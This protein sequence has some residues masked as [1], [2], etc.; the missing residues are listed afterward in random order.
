MFENKEATTIVFA[1]RNRDRTN[2]IFE[3]IKQIE[4]D[5]Q[6]LRLKNNK[7]SEY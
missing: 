6:K 7:Q 3:D 5:C 2:L 1:W 4:N